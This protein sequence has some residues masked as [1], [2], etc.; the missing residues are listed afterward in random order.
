[1]SQV[2]A[3]CRIGGLEENADRQM[4][5]I[6]DAGFVVRPDHVVTEYISGG[7]KAE[8]RPEL[9]A[10]LNRI[11]ERDVLVVHE[12]DGLGRDAINIEEVVGHFQFRGASVYCLQLGMMDLAAEEGEEVMNVIGVMAAF[13]RKLLVE[14]TQT[15]LKRAQASGKKLG[16][17][18]SLAPELEQEI[19]QRLEAGGKILTLA[20]EFDVDRKAV[21]RIRDHYL[22]SDAVNT[23]ADA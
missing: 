1:M 3:Y 12:L 17:P 13:E 14:R 16:R 21:R 19:R 18:S 7:M 9:S 8:L 5:A 22:N 4:N 20:K 15:G 6:Y 10:L 11:N 23:D 2:Y